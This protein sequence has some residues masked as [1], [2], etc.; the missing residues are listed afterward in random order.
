[1]TTELKPTTAELQAAGD[2]LVR[3]TMSAG[4]HGLFE[5][6]RKQIATS[7]GRHYIHAQMDLERVIDGRFSEYGHQFA[8]AFDQTAYR[9]LETAAITKHTGTDLFDESRISLEI[10]RAW[11]GDIP[12]LILG[13]ASEGHVLTA[14]GMAERHAT[15]IARVYR[16]GTLDTFR[17]FPLDPRGRKVQVAGSMALHQIEGR[18]LRS[19]A[20]P[21]YAARLSTRGTR[22]TAPWSSPTTPRRLPLS[23]GLVQ[24]RMVARPSSCCSSGS[25]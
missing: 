19:F 9:L 15:D 17:P 22:R 11:G 20:D 18:T 4:G 16:E 3:W 7:G 6:S 25:G 12:A 5:R 14:T 13:P 21:R 23:F 1:M 2:N 10:R 24:L 8:L